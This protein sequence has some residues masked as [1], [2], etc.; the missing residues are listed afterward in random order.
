MEQLVSLLPVLT[1]RSI[2]IITPE[3]FYFEVIMHRVIY[4]A[5]LFSQTVA[6]AF[7]MRGNCASCSVELPQLEGLWAKSDAENLMR[8]N[9]QLGHF[10][11]APQNRA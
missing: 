11:I 2:Q 6:I 10:K 1:Q 8:I 5:V 9:V 3:M 4:Y 7:M